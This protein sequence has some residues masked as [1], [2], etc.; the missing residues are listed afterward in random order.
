MMPYLSPD[1]T[2][3]GAG[4]GQVC[5]EESS[6]DRQVHGWAPSGATGGFMWKVEPRELEG[7]G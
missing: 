4:S 5:V 6:E 3:G 1:S 2:R 7:A